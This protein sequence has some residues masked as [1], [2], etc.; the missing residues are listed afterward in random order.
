METE[1]KSYKL[2]KKKNNLL[3][4]SC[5]YVSAFFAIMWTSFIWIPKSKE[6]FQVTQLN[7]A[8]S[9]PN[10]K[11]LLTLVRW[12]YSEAD[13]MMEVQF[14]MENQSFDGR[15]EYAWSAVDRRKGRLS[16]ESIYSDNEIIVVRINEVPSNWSTISLRMGFVESNPDEQPLF[17]IYG[18]ESNIQVVEW[19]ENREGRDYYILDFNNTITY[20]E[21]E[22]VKA[23]NEITNTKAK[24]KEVS[25]T[26]ENKSQKLEYMTDQELEVAMSEINSLKEMIED[27]H[28]NISDYKDSI[29]EY[30]QRILKLQEKIKAYQK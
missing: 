23:E 4:K 27:C 6:Q 8:M 20:Y 17:K 7:V 19:I 26:I 12:D 10:T 25:E 21:S 2:E 29:E 24:I 9:E 28:E 14:R 16:A 30:N 18:D 15:D 13:K 3:K 22:I 11:R 1:Y 5:I